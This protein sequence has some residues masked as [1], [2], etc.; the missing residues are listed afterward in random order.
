VVAATTGLRI[1]SLTPALAELE[2]AMCWASE[3]L[4]G[5][6]IDVTPTIQT[7]GR[8]KRCLGHFAPPTGTA[9]PPLAT[10]CGNESRKTSCPTT[11]P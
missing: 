5:M 1:D 10:H 6:D 9:I 2:R 11:R 7:R 8:K 4:E 3:D